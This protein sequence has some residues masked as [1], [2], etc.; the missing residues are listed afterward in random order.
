[1]ADE[2]Q[3]YGYIGRTELDEQ[4]N[5][6]LEKINK[7]ADDVAALKGKV[8]ANTNKVSEHT[9]SIS[10]ISN[11]MGTLS[12]L[13]T[14]NKNNLV[15]AI[16]EVFQSG[17]K[18]RQLVIDKL[19]AAKIDFDPNDTLENLITLLGNNMGGIIY[20]LACRLLRNVGDM[21]KN[22][23][24]S[25]LDTMTV[26]I[27]ENFVNYGLKT[28][29]ANSDTYV[30]MNGYSGGT[31]DSM[32]IPEGIFTGKK[33]ILF[34]YFGWCYD[35]NRGTGQKDYNGIIINM[36]GVYGD[37]TKDAPI[38]TKDKPAISLGGYS[39]IFIRGNNV[40]IKEGCTSLRSAK[41]DYM[42]EPEFS[43]RILIYNPE[44]NKV[45]KSVTI[46]SG[47]KN[48]CCVYDGGQYLYI[49]GGVHGYTTDY[50]KT[51]NRVEEWY[52]NQA[53]WRFN[54]NTLEYIELISP[55][56][57]SQGNKH[58]EILSYNVN[59]LDNYTGPVGPV[60]GVKN[61][62]FCFYRDGYLY[63]TNGEAVVNVNNPAW[64]E[65]CEG[66]PNIKNNGNGFE[67]Q[68]CYRYKDG[69]YYGFKN[70]YGSYIKRK[71]NS[72]FS[73][74][75]DYEYSKYTTKLI[76]QDKY[77]AVLSSAFTIYT[78]I[79]GEYGG[80]MYYLEPYSDSDNNDGWNVTKAS[81]NKDYCLA[82][83]SQLV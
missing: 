64:N 31:Q 26:N 20:N 35:R 27:N 65:N 6:D 75:T 57:D 69:E 44:T 24:S 14:N 2:N 53:L 12:A 76:K 38:R 37:I 66:A 40:V 80:Y 50:R 5:K 56:T 3:K 72:D 51:G 71:Y 8:E 11:K 16:N 10:N 7:S 63:N 77:D 45:V 59:T 15:A 47:F 9:T 17:S 78:S 62:S 18:I 41:S 46:S 60:E 39:Y 82:P 19:T 30:K 54:I 4:T 68:Y 36:D 58:Y 70:K 81:L 49:G 32:V 52:S 34:N 43:N 22:L 73:N 74:Y 13:N 23:A 21:D 61:Y 55:P 29:V 33:F 48:A 79:L 28:G 83:L 67:G 42:S 1:M 25:M